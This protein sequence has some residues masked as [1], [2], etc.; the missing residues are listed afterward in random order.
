VQCVP[1]G[2]CCLIDDHGGADERAPTVFH[3]PRGGVGL[4]AC[5]DPIVDE[6]CSIAWPDQVLSNGEREVALRIVGRRCAPEEPGFGFTMLVLD[7]LADLDEPDAQVLRDQRTEKRPARCD[8]DHDRWRGRRVQLC[9]CGDNVSQQ[10]RVAP[11]PRRIGFPVMPPECTS[12]SI[13][14]LLSSLQ[15]LLPLQPNA[16]LPSLITTIGWKIDVRREVDNLSIQVGDYA[17]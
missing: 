4:C 13:E 15:S 10:C 11:P 7:V 3:Q 17:L 2:S 12:A 8:A 14:V 6:H 1:N 9:Q 16:L 5:L